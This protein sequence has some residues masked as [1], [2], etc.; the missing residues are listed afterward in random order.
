MAFGTTELILIFVVL[1]L[2]VAVIGLIVYLVLRNAKKQTKVCQH[3]AERIQ[4]A[5]KICRFCQREV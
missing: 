3:C 1:G 2:P 4:I 5:A